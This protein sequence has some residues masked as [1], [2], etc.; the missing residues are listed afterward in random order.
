MVFGSDLV[1]EMLFTIVAP[2]LIRRKF[3]GFDPLGCGAES[4][5]SY[6]YFAFWLV[7]LAWPLI[8]TIANFCKVL[9]YELDSDEDGSD[10]DDSSSSSYL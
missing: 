9:I 4:M 8:S 10:E 5:Y 7:C 1:L 6:R 3:D 2:K